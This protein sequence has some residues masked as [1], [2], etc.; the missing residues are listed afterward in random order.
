MENEFQVYFACKEH[1]RLW[2]QVGGE[3]RRFENGLL[4]PRNTED[5][6]NIRKE[7][8][9]IDPR[10]ATMIIEVDREAAA[11][12]VRNMLAKGPA[13]VSGGVTAGAMS[14]ALQTV[15]AANLQDQQTNMSPAELE[16]FQQAQREVG[17]LPTEN[18][19]R[20]IFGKS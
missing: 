2:L 13:V 7:L 6:A 15:N 9:L 16:A 4:Y 14:Q 19:K 17:L 5:L 8:Q 18:S 3:L 10:V 12:E 20:P 11:R 1:P